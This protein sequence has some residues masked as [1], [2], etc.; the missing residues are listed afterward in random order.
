M[1][2]FFSRGKKI[3]EQSKAVESSQIEKLDQKLVT[4]LAGKQFPKIHQWK[5]LPKFLTL[6]EKRLL[7]IIGVAALIGAALFAFFLSRDES[8]LEPASG[9][10]LHEGVVGTPR[11]I[12]PI[13]AA[14]DADRDLARLIFSSLLFYDANGILRNDLAENVETNDSG[15]LY[16]FTLKEAY[17][18]DGEP[19]RAEDVL[20]TIK[21]IQDPA[22]K[23]PLWRSFKGVEVSAIDD[24]TVQFK[25]EKPYAPFIHALTVGIAPAHLWHNLD[26]EIAH[27]SVWATKPIG[28]GPWQFDTLTKTKEGALISYTLKKNTGYYGAVPWLDSLTISF[29][30][31]LKSALRALKENRIESLAFIPSSMRPELP[32]KRVNSHPLSIPSY[33]AVFWNARKNTSLEGAEV[34]RALSLAIDRQA[35]SKETGGAPLDGLSDLLNAQ[36]ENLAKPQN[37][38]EAQNLLSKNGWQKKDSFWQKNGEVLSLTLTSLLDPD[39]Q[40]ISEILAK[41]WETLGVKTSI[42]TLDPAELKEALKTRNYEA[43]LWGQILGGS[44]DLFPLWHSSQTDDPGLYLSSIKNRAVDALLENLTAVSDTAKQREGFEKIETLM[45]ENPPAAI[46]LRPTYWYAMTKN[47]HGVVLQNIFTPADRFLEASAWYVKRKF[48]F[49]KVQ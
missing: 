22:W 45:E 38:E 2:P 15:A 13:R 7:K 40:K 28:S 4:S 6:G 8:R 1:L 9:G 48:S 31:N 14:S 44:H 18:H 10:S 23:S 20:F 17:W 21:A 47:A 35:L 27:L 46:L 25:L 3:L 49:F 5:L 16:T 24:R 26:P 37:L 34:R 33:T 29:Y 30:Q 42:A 39:Y 43:L 41:S 11:F 36:T 19:V 32:N 12:N